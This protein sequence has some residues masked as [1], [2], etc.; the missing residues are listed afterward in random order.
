M[1]ET[2]QIVL[3]VLA[4]VIGVSML[5]DKISGVASTNSRRDKEDDS[6]E[7]I[8]VTDDEFI[9][10]LK[11]WS[12]FKSRC[13]VAGL[14]EVVKR[15]YEIFPLLVVAEQANKQAIKTILVKERDNEWEHKVSSYNILAGWKFLWWT[16]YRSC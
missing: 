12:F 11:S 2:Y 1:M 3:L 16:N 7:Y 4:G 13:E 10:I 14:E 15:L 8:P 6:E 9:K 5:W